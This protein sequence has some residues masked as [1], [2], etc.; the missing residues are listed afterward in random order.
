MSKKELEKRIEGQENKI[1]L[2][3]ELLKEAE[4]IL[5]CL[6]LELKDEDKYQS[7]LNNNADYFS[8]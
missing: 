1:K 6:K 3:K 2:I 8:V 7:V 5:F 4:D